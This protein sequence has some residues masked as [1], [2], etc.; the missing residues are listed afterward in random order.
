MESLFGYVWAEVEGSI[1]GGHDGDA[2]TNEVFG[3]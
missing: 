2:A 1:F 3:V